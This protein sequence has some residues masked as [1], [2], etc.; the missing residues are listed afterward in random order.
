MP[1]AI[2]T[3]YTG[4]AVHNHNSAYHAPVTELGGGFMQQQTS[5]KGHGAATDYYN[6]QPMKPAHL[7]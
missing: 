7:V 5:Y 6:S 2:P 4:P 3:P 1:S